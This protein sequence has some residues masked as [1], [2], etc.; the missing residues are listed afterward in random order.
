MVGENMLESFKQA[1]W[2]DI[3]YV[4]MSGDPP[5]ALQL[6][7]I[8]LLFFLIYARRRLKGTKTRQNDASYFVH[9]I[10]VLANAT[11]LVQGNFI[12]Y[13]AH[14]ALVIWHKFLQIV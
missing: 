2:S 12:S 1:H 4:L 10:I 3:Y 5:L 7:L 11:L 14:N 6:L 9:G 8:N 13:Y